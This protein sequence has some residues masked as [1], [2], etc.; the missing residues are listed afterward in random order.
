[1]SAADQTV[2]V[3]MEDEEQL[4]LT[5]AHLPTLADVPLNPALKVRR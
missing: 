1:M 2:V 5:N 3:V 4:D